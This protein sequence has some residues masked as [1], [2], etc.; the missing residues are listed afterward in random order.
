VKL[1]ESDEEQL[2]QLKNW[3]DEN[4]TSLVLTVVI[5]LGGVFG[6]RAWEANVQQT[7][8][9]A[10]AAYEDL[11]AAVENIDAD[12]EIMRDT[13]QSLATTL[14]SDFE[15]SAYS[16]FGA[17]HMARL[18]V[19]AGDLDTAQSELEWALENA[20]E[21]QLDTLI[22]IRLARVLNA[23]GDATAA[24]ALLINHEPPVGQLVSFEETR[25]D[26]FHALGDLMNARD[27]Y[28]KAIDALAEGETRPLLELK[29]ADIP[30]TP[31]ADEGA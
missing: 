24:M 6:F 5:A 30:K 7:G 8:E 18:A 3:W 29:L 17:L 28:Q 26:T 27:A 20:G 14:R 19:D 21:P 2:E 15:G 23:S 25:G 9:A 11:V 12:E 4:G 31:A 1:V 22:R 16:V 10:S 13:A